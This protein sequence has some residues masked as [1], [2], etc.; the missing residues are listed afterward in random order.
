[1]FLPNFRVLKKI[2]PIIL[3]V[4]IGVAAVGIIYYSSLNGVDQSSELIK[5]GVMTD[6]D[7]V[8][9]RSVSQALELAAEQLNDEGG[10]IGRQVEVIGENAEILEPTKI[11]L[12]LTR[13]LAFHKVDFVIGVAGS[14]GLMAQEVIA[15]HKRIFFELAGKQD[16]FTQRVLDDYERYK[17]YFRVIHNV[18][19]QLQNW[20]ESVLFLRELTGFN[21]I[22]YLGLDVGIFRQIMEG[23]DYFLPEV[24]GFDLVYRGACSRGT[25]DFSSYFA[26]AEAAGVEIMV[27]LFNSEAAIPFV[28]E[29]YD[30]Q[31]PMVIFGGSLGVIKDPDGWEATDGKCEYTSSDIYALRAG[32]PLTSKTLPA[33]EAYINRWNENPGFGNRGAYDILRYILPDAIERAG[34]LEVNAVIEALEE[35]NIETTN[36]R[37]FVFTESHDIMAGDPNNP[38]TNYPIT[39]QFQWQNREFVPIFPKWLMEEAGAN[40]L[41][42]PWEGPWN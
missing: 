19:S 22:G 18:T 42:P 13:L 7:T 3:L 38:E 14:E 33:R 25:I 6:F 2:Q 21:K 16:E 23:F 27:P 15:E 39:L 17:Y 35:T 10:I 37:N 12:A 24:Y 29:Y 36:A 26:Q 28:K 30:R 8:T 31:S 1:L 4:I 34:T 41:Y 11:N 9:G 20:I 40:Y 32:Y 5:I